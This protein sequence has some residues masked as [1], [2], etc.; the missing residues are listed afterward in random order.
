[1]KALTTAEL[2][3]GHDLPFG[4]AADGDGVDPDRLKAGRL[5]RSQTGQHASQALPPCDPLEGILIERVEA[6]VEPMQ[7]RSTQVGGLLLQQ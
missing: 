5:G 3:Q 4:E 7:A 6:D 2:C 1:M